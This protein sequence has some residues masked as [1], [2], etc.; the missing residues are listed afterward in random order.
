MLKR[1]IYLLSSILYHILLAY[2]CYKISIGQSNFISAFISSR[3]I[4]GICFFVVQI[5]INIILMAH[6]SID[7]PIDI[8]TPNIGLF[9]LKFKR[10]YYS[11]LG[12]FWTIKIKDKIHVFQQNYFYLKRL[13][14]VNNSDNINVITNNIKSE[15]DYRLQK[16]IENKKF[17]D[18]YKNWNGFL[19]KQSER[20]GKLND[21]GVK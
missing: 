6:E 4:I 10:I 18:T 11:K 19:D 21:I 8:L 1:K 12:Y 15:L 2:I 7:Q 3:I 16:E 20:D 14:Y 13:F 5:L 9:T 17:N